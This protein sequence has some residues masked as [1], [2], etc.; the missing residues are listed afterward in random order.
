MD[1]WKL[2]DDLRS[3]FLSAKDRGFTDQQV[4]LA[5]H[6]IEQVVRSSNI[7]VTQ[8]YQMIPFMDLLEKNNVRAR[9]SEK[10]GMTR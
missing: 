1:F 8:R 9:E 3:S 6:C 4:N 5:R 2:R 7:D 10:E